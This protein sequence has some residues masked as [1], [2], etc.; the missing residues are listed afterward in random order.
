M[1][2]V[3]DIDAELAIAGV[4]HG[5]VGR[6]RLE[7][8]FL[9]EAGDMRNMGLAIL[10][11]IASV[12][13]DDRGGIV[14]DPG[15]CLLVDRD[16]DHHL[17]LPGEVLHEPDRRPVRNALGRR[18]PFRV[19]ARTEIGLV[20]HLLQAQHLHARLTGLVDQGNM[21]LQHRL[22]DLLRRL[23][24]RRLEAHLDEPSTNACHRGFLPF[25]TSVGTLVIILISML[26][27]DVLRAV[28]L[29]MTAL[30]V[31]HANPA[32]RCFPR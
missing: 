21:R 14:I 32:K 19:L 24:G 9:P 12:G 16:H 15:H 6:A 13:V 28:R 18:I 31:A 26:E 1:A 2:V 11:E 27:N 22:G 29:A 25:M 10:A 20:E 3:A 30:P 5:V 4:E 17:V 7:E 8:E 23:L